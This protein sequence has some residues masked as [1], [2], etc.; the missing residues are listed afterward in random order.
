MH[1]SSGSTVLTPKNQ[2]N[3]K[4]TAEKKLQLGKIKIASLSQSKPNGANIYTESFKVC[5]NDIS[6]GAPIC[7]VD[8]CRF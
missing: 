5:T 2:F 4:K 6:Q 1:S 3:M 7:S 8:S